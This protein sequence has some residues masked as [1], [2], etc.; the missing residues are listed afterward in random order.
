MILLILLA[1][2]AP[3]PCPVDSEAP[4][5][6]DVYYLCQY[7]EDDPYGVQSAVAVPVHEG[8]GWG[9]EECPVDNGD[10][11][12]EGCVDVSSEYKLYQGL[13]CTTEDEKCYFL[14]LPCEDTYRKITVYKIGD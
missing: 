6:P 2:C 8:E 14:V 11:I 7:L 10:F 9:V 5:P 13:V 1:A 4:P 3:D 12:D